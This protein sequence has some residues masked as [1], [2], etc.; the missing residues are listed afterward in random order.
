MSNFISRSCCGTF[1]AP[2]KASTDRY[3]YCSLRVR[4]EL[5]AI[6]HA[7]MSFLLIS[8]SEWMPESYPNLSCEFCVHVCCVLCLCACVCVRV[9]SSRENL[10][11][12]QWIWTIN[13]KMCQIWINLNSVGVLTGTASTA[14]VQ[15][16]RDCILSLLLLGTFQSGMF[17]TAD[18]MTFD[19][20]AGTLR[21]QQNPV[22]R[23]CRWSFMQGRC[24]SS[25]FC[26]LWNLGA[27]HRVTGAQLISTWFKNVKGTCP[28][29]VLLF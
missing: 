2:H 17:Q 20:I 5:R 15:A 16:A 24:L 26:S 29:L 23:F 27:R 22:I 9:S 4:K 10:N 28:S 12:V 13:S 25:G 14:E 7:V 8:S 3:P 18:H 21:A 1:A 11:Y 19:V 6:G